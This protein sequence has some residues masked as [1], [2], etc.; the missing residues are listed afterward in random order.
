MNW[1]FF[2]ISFPLFSQSVFQN[3]IK[4]III[5]NKHISDITSV[6]DGDV[7]P[8]IYINNPNF[9]DLPVSEKKIKFID[10][11][12]P[13]ILLEKDKI[14]KG[15]NYVLDHFDNTNIND[16]IQSLY[17][18]CNC[19]NSYDLL[20]CLKE[21][22]NS[23]IIAQAAIESGWGTSRFFLEGNN[24]FGIHTYNNDV[25]NLEANNSSLVYVKKYNNISESISHYLRTLA[26]GY[27]YE[28]YR[29]NRLKDITSIELIQELIMYSER[30]DFYV[31]DLKSIIDYNN[32]TIYDHLELKHD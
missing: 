13:A 6:Q 19:D 1:L 31:K 32:L 3:S 23:I 28:N 17:D 24:L 18:Y 16:T 12:L 5:D 2:F 22:P 11:I 25:N 30:R 7:A 29:V 14:K 10:F 9:S 15:Y 8:I 20:L 27:A 21:Q 4:N 26:K